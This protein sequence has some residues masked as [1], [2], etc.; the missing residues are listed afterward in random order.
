MNPIKELLSL[1]GKTVLITGGAVNI[2]RATA[3]RLAQAG[4]NIAIIYHKSA[5]EIANLSQEINKLGVDHITLQAN[6]TNETEVKNVLNTIHEHF[7]AID[8]LVNNAG[9]F[10][11]SMQE[12]LQSDEWDKVFDLNVKGLFMIT[13]ECIKQMKQNTR[14]G[15]IVN[16]ASINGLHPGF[17]Q[18][19]H[20]DASKGAVIAYTKS[21][22]GE[23]AQFN[24]R[25]N[26]VAPGL[27]DSKN[28]RTYAPDL[29][30]MVE[31]RTPLQKI[32]THEDIA[33]AVLFLSSKI[34][35]H[36][37]GEVIVV[38]GGYLLT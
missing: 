31:K 8:V 36:I 9:V 35:S 15:A 4:A 2:G 22:A 18:T 13:R 5:G 7:G 23:L 27:V 3:L 37:T 1:K 14:G 16:M 21:L 6:I 19:A 10:G 38:D 34:S 17:G 12:D 29:A 26:A 25:I 20:Y 33:N 28:L 11:L 32:A 24:I 30:Q